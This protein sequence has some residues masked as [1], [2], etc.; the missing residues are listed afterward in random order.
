MHGYGARHTPK[1]YGFI[2][3]TKMA[4]RKPACNIAHATV[5]YLCFFWFRYHHTGSTT[6]TASTRQPKTTIKRMLQTVTPRGV[7]LT[8]GSNEMFGPG[9]WNNRKEGL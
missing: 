7:S 8:N 6:A 1:L 9:R 4:C 5:W 2:S 3:G